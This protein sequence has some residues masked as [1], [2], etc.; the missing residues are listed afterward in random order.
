M[1]FSSINTALSALRY[2]QVALDTASHNIANVGTEGYTRRRVEA[3]SAG[4]PT[5]PA[6]WSRNQNAGGGVR[7]TGV[8]RMTDAFL[9]ARVRTEHGKQSYLDTRQAVLDR[10]E[11]GIG[12]PGENGLSAVMAEFRQGWAD[13]ANNPST[14]A[15][16]S[17][18]LARGASL[19]D[20][21][22]IQAR[23]FT[24]EAGDQRARVNVLVA[25]VDTIAS[26]L[27]A[28]NKAIQVAQLDGSDAGNLLDQR[29]LLA[30]RLSKLTGGTTTANGTGGLD[31][32]VNGVA[33]VTGGIAGRLEVASGVTPTGEAD[34]NPVTF[35]VV[36]PVDGTSAVP[37][38][39]GGEIGAVRD[40]LDVT[41]PGYLAGLGEVARALADAV[42]ALHQGGYDAAGAAGAPFFTY[43][44]ADPAGTLEVG[45][46]DPADV[47]ASGVAGGAVDGSVADALAELTAPE[48]GYQ[49]LV[50]GFGTTVASS[51]R[52]ADSQMMLT[53]QVDG[54][55]D[56]LAGVSL[57][58]EMLSMVEYQRGYEAAA[59]VLTTVDSIL[60]TLINRTGLTR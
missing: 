43:D 20:A 45:I 40:L 18:V 51:R 1:S 19:A 9:D 53:Q 52:L 28:T 41:I 26:D 7:I 17:Q 23:N 15:A 3:A 11:T 47:A 24:T 33:L 22:Q 13:L 14:D 49:Q 56:Q 8:T 36:H 25:E 37:D 39:V 38:G 59:R 46:T 34:G 21:V 31:V 2:N 5:T 50:N 10:L 55:R 54:A 27:A 48:T 32:A 12:E 29:D 60:D 58:E 44:P 16:R 30:L 42:N 6:M 35:Q 57:D 4:T